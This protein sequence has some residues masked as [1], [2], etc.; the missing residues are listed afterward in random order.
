MDVDASVQ[1]FR[2]N[3]RERLRAFIERSVTQRIIIILILINAVLLGME[4]W[5][6]AMQVAV[7]TCIVHMHRVR[8]CIVAFGR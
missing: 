6:A 1:P 7:Y 3:M 8:S 5:P 2:G 4:T